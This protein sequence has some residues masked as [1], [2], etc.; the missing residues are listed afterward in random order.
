MRRGFSLLEVIFALALLAALALGLLA[1]F[2][3]GL[4]LST[5]NRETT[6]CAKV[7]QQLLENLR[8]RS[9]EFP[10][11]PQ[12]FRATQSDPQMNGFPPAPYPRLVLGIQKYFVNVQIEPVTGQLHLYSVRVLVSWPDGSHR[13]ELQT[14]YLRD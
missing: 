14:Y 5:Q 1:L 8:D 12:N 7:A 13:V 11:T 3:N 4:K 2:I 10:K 9:L 6:K